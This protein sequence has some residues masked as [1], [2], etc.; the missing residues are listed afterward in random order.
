VGCCE[1]GVENFDSMKGGKFL[2]LA[3]NASWLPKRPVLC[4]VT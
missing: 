3:G 1:H 2:D 4:G